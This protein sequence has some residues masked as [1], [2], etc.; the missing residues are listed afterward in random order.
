MADSRRII[1]PSGPNGTG[2]RDPRHDALERIVPSAALRF[3]A[4]RAFVDGTEAL[5]SAVLGAN[6]R[7]RSVSLYYPATDPDTSAAN[8]DPIWL[9]GDPTEAGEGF[10]LEPGAALDVDV[11]GWLYGWSAAASAPTL[12]TVELED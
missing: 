1:P 7:R 9:C 11:A 5:P 2:A 8:T 10:P 12:Y 3:R 4:R 6:S